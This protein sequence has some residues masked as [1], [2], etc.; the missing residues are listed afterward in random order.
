MMFAVAFSFPF[1]F[2]FVSCIISS[3]FFAF[4]DDAGADVAAGVYLGVADSGSGIAGVDSSAGVAA[5]VGSGPVKSQF[6]AVS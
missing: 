6:E 2:A 3:F 5:G 4:D 1:P